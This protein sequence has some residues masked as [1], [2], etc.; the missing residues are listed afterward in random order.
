MLPVRD[1]TKKKVITKKNVEIIQ[2]L[3]NTMI[4]YTNIA[5][6]RKHNWFEMQYYGKNK[7]KH[8]LDGTR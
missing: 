1:L 7:R 3:R 8:R 4:S 6:S 5:S 2:V